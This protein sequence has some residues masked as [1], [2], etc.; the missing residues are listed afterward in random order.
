MEYKPDW[1]SL[2]LKTPPGSGAGNGGGT[3][4][5]V[6]VG[7]VWRWRR[8]GRWWIQRSLARALLNKETEEAKRQ[9][10]FRKERDEHCREFN[11]FHSNFCLII[12]P[13]YHSLQD[14]VYEPVKGQSLSSGERLILNYKL[15]TDHTWPSWRL[16][17]FNSGIQFIFY[18]ILNI[19]LFQDNNIYWVSAIWWRSH[20]K[21]GNSE[22][23]FKKFFLSISI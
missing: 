6:K 17:Y 10:E 8:Q 3:G 12:A 20:V 23:G 13:S 5:G 16:L 19:P 2:P 14:G 9:A 7:G 22:L 15:R 21:E 18:F 11:G 1:T 4:N